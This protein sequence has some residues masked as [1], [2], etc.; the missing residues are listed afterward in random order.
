MSIL[1]ALEENH[2]ILKVGLWKNSFL[3]ENHKR[4]LYYR[5]LQRIILMGALTPE[6]IHFDTKEKRKKGAHGQLGAHGRLFRFDAMTP[7]ARPNR[8][9][10]TKIKS[11]FLVYPSDIRL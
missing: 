10:K 3:I 1:I 9:S 8:E 11:S 5:P 6:N 7:E 4:N 2:F